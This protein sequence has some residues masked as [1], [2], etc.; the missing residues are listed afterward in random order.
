M[1]WNALEANQHFRERTIVTVLKENSDAM[2]KLQE[3]PTQSP[4]PKSAT[5][6]PVLTITALMKLKITSIARLRLTIYASLLLSMIM[7]SY[8]YSS[9]TLSYTSTLLNHPQWSEGLPTKATIR[10]MATSAISTSLHIETVPVQQSM[11]EPDDDD[12]I[13]IG[14][15]SS[16]NQSFFHNIQKEID[17]LEDPQKR[18]QRYNY[19]YD[20][21]STTTTTPRRIFYGSLI[22][23]ETYELLNIM[24]TETYQIYSGMVFVESNR[25]Q[26]FVYTRDWKHVDIGPTNTDGTS[27]YRRQQMIA[28][29]FGLEDIHQVRIKPFINEDRHLLSL[30]REQKQRDLILEGWKE[31]GMQPEDIGIIS[32]LDE[33]FTRDYLRA[34]QTCSDIPQ[35]QYHKHYCHHESVKIIARALVYES[36]PQCRTHHRLW[37]HPDIIIGHCID[38]I[39]DVQMH[40][41]APRES[42]RS[43]I[44]APGFGHDCFDWYNESKITNH[45]YPSWSAADFRRTCSGGQHTFLNQSD[46]E[47][48][49]KQQQQSKQHTGYH[50]HNFFIHMNTTRYKYFSYGHADTEVY[51]KPLHQ[52]S[53]DLQLMYN[54]VNDIP[55]HID[56]KWKRSTLNDVLNPLE[57]PIYFMD[58]EY[59]QRRHE[60]VRDMVKADDEMYAQMLSPTVAP[61]PKDTNRGIAPAMQGQPIEPQQFKPFF[62]TYNDRDE[63]IN[64][65]VMAMATNYD[66]WTYKRFVGSLRYSGYKGH[67]IVALE[68]DPSPKIVNYL[69][70]KNVT[71]KILSWI[72]CTYMTMD[73]DKE[74]DIFKNTTCASPYPDIKIRWSRFP[75]MRD[76]LNECTTCTGPILIADARDLIFQRNP[77]DIHAP[78]VAGL[79]VY[80]EHANLTTKNW[81]TA[82]PLRECKGVIY[83][84]PMLCSSTTIGT[85]E[86]ILEYLNMMYEEMKVW[87]NDPKCRFNINGDDQ[88]I[89][90]FLYYSGRFPNETTVSVPNRMGGIVNTIGYH[91][92]TLQRQYILSD[93]EDTYPGASRT[94]WIGRNEFGITND[95]GLFVELDG[96]TI[97]RVVHQWDRFS[98]PYI[99]WL[100]QQPWARF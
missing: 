22:A 96:T 62:D 17:D 20:F 81:L 53:K 15:L 72:N 8:W 39:A 75:L 24:A 41:S 88:S 98:T 40:P 51:Q 97:S 93:M 6:K 86:T 10:T 34:I 35:F 90:N 38:G 67:I 83:D 23:D 46:A 36:S 1:L 79:Q 95:D 94:T 77:F 16:F 28:S 31:L 50:F 66:L 84:V 14:I 27:S 85:R 2:M 33:T 70:D 100:K 59:R 11:M 52:L 73:D 92:A 60:H 69:L 71:V 89:H 61:K 65:T 3:L 43:F 74:S 80:Q 7:V 64:A 13:D 49:Q 18:C 57:E 55:D 58:P 87:I 91:A 99:R 4:L 9:R 56:Q 68:P 54:C 63:S 25:T 21:N 82:W 78:K 45:Q 48:Q 5:K 12:P 37:Y 26:S 47:Q 32:D 44:R 30:Y 42:A 19:K 29:L 76:W